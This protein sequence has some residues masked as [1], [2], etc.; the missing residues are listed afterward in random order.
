MTTSAPQSDLVL[1]I[2]A[3]QGKL[4]LSLL[5]DVRTM[6]SNAGCNDFSVKLS[7]ENAADVGQLARVIE[8]AV[9]GDVDE[10]WMQERLQ[11]AVKHGTYYFNEMDITGL[12]MAALKT[13]LV[14]AGHSPDLKGARL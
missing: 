4:F 13:A 8:R 12:L 1:R 9:N 10:S 3:M 2:P 7:P 14:E 6:Q 5:E 11:S